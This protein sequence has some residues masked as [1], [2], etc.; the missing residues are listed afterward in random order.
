MATFN[1]PPLTNRYIL[2][3][4]GFGVII[5][6]WLTIEENTVW[7]ASALGAILAYA[8]KWLILRGQWGGRTFAPRIWLVGGVGLGL[9]GGLGAVFMTTVLMVMKNAQHS[10]ANL[11][12]PSAVITGIWARTPY[13]LGAGLFVNLGIV[14]LILALYSPGEHSEINFREDEDDA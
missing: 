12:F 3:V 13:W 7:V 2:C 10:H 6:L 1:L 9:L 14:L 8:L 5:M 4:I 11:D